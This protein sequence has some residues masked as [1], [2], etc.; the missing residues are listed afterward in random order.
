M[1]YL[2]VADV[3]IDDLLKDDLALSTMDEDEDEDEDHYNGV[4]HDEVV[5]SDEKPCK[6]IYITK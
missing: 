1:L 5:I 2:F 3:T 6:C 4:S